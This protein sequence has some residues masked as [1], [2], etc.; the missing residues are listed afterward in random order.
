MARR[1]L[2]LGFIGVFVGLV[3]SGDVLIPFLFLDRT[4][5]LQSLGRSVAATTIG[6]LIGAAVMW[7]V[8][9]RWIIPWTRKRA[10]RTL[11]EEEWT[12]GEKNA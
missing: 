2:L 9:I 8:C 10:L 4:L 7:Q 6:S 1:N 12:N 11:Q 5:S 3:V